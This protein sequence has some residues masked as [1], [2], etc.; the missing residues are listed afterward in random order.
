MGLVE[1]DD[2]L[3]RLD[4]L[5]VERL[6][7]V[8]DWL[9][10]RIVLVVE[11]APFIAALRAEDLGDLLPGVRAGALELPVDQLRPSDPVA[12]GGPE[13]RLERAACDPAVGRLVGEV[14]DEPPGQLKV[15]ARRDDRGT[16]VT[17]S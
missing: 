4:Q 12:E 16:E 8:E 17:G 10:H 6:A 5:R 7:E 11:G 3:P 15:A 14:A 13:L 9:D 2:H 1:L